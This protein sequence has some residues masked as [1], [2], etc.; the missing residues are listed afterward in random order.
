LNNLNH[1]FERIE[2]EMGGD[3]GLYA[4]PINDAARGEPLTYNADVRFPAASTIKVFVLLTLLRDAQSGDCLLSEEREVTHGDKVTGSGV[5][6]SLSSGRHY[7]L[8]DLATLMIIVSDNT[9]TNLLIDRLG[10]PRI[11]G[12]IQR[13]GWRGTQLT[14]RLQRAESAPSTST[15]RDLGGF[16]QRLWTDELLNDQHTDVA[17][18]IFEQQQYTEQLGRD[19]P[20]DAY[21]TEIGESTFRI[22]SKSGAL[23]GVRNDAGV[24]THQHGQ[25]VLSVMTKNCPDLRFH[26][27]NA[28]S[29]AIS[30]AS[31][32]VFDAFT[33]GQT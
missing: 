25:Y 11:N 1:T 33:N 13:H 26:A 10:I 7:T 3:L 9:A 6:K 31:R 20:F 14:S 19:L 5:L 2:H 24:I 27:N 22:G 15:P 23:R 21:S 29:L 4:I 28:G 30:R 17:K 32:A 12:D 16:F 18:R 8:L